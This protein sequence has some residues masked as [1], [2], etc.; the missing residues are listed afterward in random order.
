MDLSDKAKRAIRLLSAGKNS[1]SC[2]K[3]A[4]FCA[5]QNLYKADDGKGLVQSM[6]MLSCDSLENE[7]RPRKLECTNH[8]V[9]GPNGRE[10]FCN[11]AKSMT[12]AA[13]YNHVLYSAL[14]CLSWWWG[15]ASLTEQKKGFELWR[16]RRGRVMGG[17]IVSGAAS[18]F[19]LSSRTCPLSIE[20]Q[21]EKAKLFE[22]RGRSYEFLE[23]EAFVLWRNWNRRLC[24][25]CSGEQDA[26]WMEQSDIQHSKAFT[27]IAHI[28]REAGKLCVQAFDESKAE[29]IAWMRHPV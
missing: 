27:G 9:V 15:L 14:Q 3:D 10:D 12:I 16:R 5:L 2:V 7:R 26:P 22:P 19:V 21:Q 23:K 8:N 17:R 28:H 24:P 29:N 6:D 25:T 13:D 1:V 4:D 11:M 20:L 18:T